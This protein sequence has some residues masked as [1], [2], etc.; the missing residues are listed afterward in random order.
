MG[1]TIKTVLKVT[2]LSFTFT[3]PYLCISSLIVKDV[4]DVPNHDTC[5][6]F[7]SLVLDRTLSP[8]TFMP[9]FDI[10]TLR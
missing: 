7:V 9:G 1:S 5:Y 8:V 3:V 4:R 10:K 6:V 2:L